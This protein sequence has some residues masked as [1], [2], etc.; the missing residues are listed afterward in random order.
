MKYVA[1]LLLM[2]L[3]TGCASEPL[4]EQQQ[5]ERDDREVLRLEQYYKD[6][7]NC[8]A[9]GGMM[10]ID[11][12]MSGGRFNRNRPPRRD[13]RYGCIGSRDYERM[14]REMGMM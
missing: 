7:A 10:H 1:L 6:V 9:S 2:V 11:R 13:E 4:T 14:M 8:E 5:Y 3:I 12:Y